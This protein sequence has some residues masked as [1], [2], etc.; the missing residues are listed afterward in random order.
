MCVW[1][2]PGW[3]AGSILS[4]P[5]ASWPARFFFLRP[6]SFGRSSRAAASAEGRPADHLISTSAIGSGCDHQGVGGDWLSFPLRVAGCGTMP[7]AVTPAPDATRLPLPMQQQSTR[8]PAAARPYF[9]RLKR[10]FAP[11]NTIKQGVSDQKR[12]GQDIFIGPC[13]CVYPNTRLQGYYSV[14]DYYSLPRR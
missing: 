10:N 4:G 1:P 8:T 14:N 9:Y 13:S 5:P 12:V 11:L 2:W 6:D 7:A 3:G